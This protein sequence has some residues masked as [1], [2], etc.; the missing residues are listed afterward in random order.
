MAMRSIRIGTRGSALALRQTELLVSALHA[1]HSRIDCAVTVLSTIG[2]RNVSGPLS[3]FG[4][5]GA[6]IA[7]FEDALLSGRIDLAV[8]SAKDMPFELAPSLGI[9]MV[10]PRADA[11]D[12]LLYRKGRHPRVARNAVIGTGSPRRAAQIPYDTRLL[13][14][15]VPTRIQ[16]LKAGE[17]DAIILASAGLQRL[18]LTDD[19]ELEYETLPYERMV[20]AGG[21]GIIAVEGPASSPLADLLAPCCDRSAMIELETERA[22]LRH[23]KAGCHE[24]VGV[25]AQVTEGRLTLRFFCARGGRPVR[26]CVSGS[27]AQRFDLARAVAEEADG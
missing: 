27:V 13:R 17:Y 7:E 21:Q 11:R 16:K 2:D 5:K 20:P 25:H 12:V 15:N 6:F 9:L 14:G 10:L 3:E 18:G 24:P 23:L 1:R 8:H 19:P 22:V 26:A 4:G